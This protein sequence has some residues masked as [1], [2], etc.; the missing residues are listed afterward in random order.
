MLTYDILIFSIVVLPCIIIST[1][2][3]LRFSHLF[4]KYEHF[5]S[6]ST[7]IKRQNDSKIRIFCSLRKFN[8]VKITQLHAVKCFSSKNGNFKTFHQDFL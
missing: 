2:I 3:L 5:E 8:F 6:S 1:Q 7:K 4:K